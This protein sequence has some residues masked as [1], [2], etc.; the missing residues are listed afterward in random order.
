MFT[1]ADGTV[2]SRLAGFRF[3]ILGMG[4]PRMPRLVDHAAPIFGPGGHHANSG[5]TVTFAGSF[6]DQAETIPIVVYYE[7]ETDPDAAIALSLVLLLIYVVV[8]RQPYAPG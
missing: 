5:A 6:R 1:G 4:I 7:L 8:P 2:G 3:W